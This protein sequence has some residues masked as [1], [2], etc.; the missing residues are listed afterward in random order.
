ML[1]P[2]LPRPRLV[3]VGPITDPV[4]TPGGELRAYHV[5]RTSLSGLGRASGPVA[6]RRRAPERCPV[7]PG[8]VP[9]GSQPISRLGGGRIPSVADSPWLGE[10]HGACSTSPGLTR[11]LLP[12]SRPRCCSP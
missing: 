4:A 10:P 9:F 6:L 8:H 5:P 11:P 2:S 1:R 12:G 3:A 7:A